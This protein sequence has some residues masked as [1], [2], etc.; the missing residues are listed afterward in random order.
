MWRDLVPAYT[1]AHLRLDRVLTGEER[2][3]LREDHDETA[4]MCPSGLVATAARAGDTT[5]LTAPAKMRAASLT[6]SVA[7]ACAVTG[8][9]SKIT[10]TGLTGIPSN[11]SD[12][13]TIA[14]ATAIFKTTTNGYSATL[15]PPTPLVA[16]CHIW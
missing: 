8:W 9:D 4:S 10:G 11:I 6:P 2:G 5:R 16:I 13:I 14:G 15:M 1:Y 12:S 7:M 3:C